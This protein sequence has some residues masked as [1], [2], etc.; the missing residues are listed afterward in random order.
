MTYDIAIIGAGPAGC[1]F[2]RQIART[3]KKILLVDGQNIKNRKPCGGLLAPD[4]QKIF[5]ELDLTLPGSVLVSPQIFSVKVTDLESGFVAHYQRHYLNMDRYAF[6][7]YLISQ[8]PET[9]DIVEG[10][11]S[12]IKRE[13]GLFSVTV[14][15]TVYTAGFLVGADGAGSMV[16][17]TFIGG[18]M[19]HFTAIQQF[20]NAEGDENPYYSCIF[21]SKTSPS[22]SWTMFK[23]G[24]LIYGGCFPTEGSREAFERQKKRF[25]KFIGRELG[26][27]TRTEACLVCNPKRFRD[28]KT[29]A[30][31]VFLIG[32]AAGFISSSSFEGF[33]SAFSSAL[34]LADAFGRHGDSPKA[35]LRSYKRLTLRLRVKLWLKILKRKVICSPF[36]RRIIMKSGVSAIKMR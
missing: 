22:C 29:G 35:V 10:R 21:D 15:E 8:V 17:K 14:G 5:A 36:L 34:S 32:E 3:G 27:P 18:K 26:E 4:A 20:F 30:D 25:E 6:D 16:R 9:V 33:S 1:L 28:F 2:A 23:N 13:S 19:P 7:R 31:N 11:C 12:G 24:S